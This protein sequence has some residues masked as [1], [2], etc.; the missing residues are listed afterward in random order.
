[1]Q[2]IVRGSE[3]CEALRAALHQGLCRIIY[4]KK[5][6]NVR[7]ASGTTDLS[8]VPE[9]QHPK[10]KRKPAQGVV[11]YYDIDKEEWRC[12]LEENLVGYSEED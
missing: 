5:D 3:D 11:T 7:V 6:G 12:L 9:S 2:F 4:K 10:G 1:M 8:R